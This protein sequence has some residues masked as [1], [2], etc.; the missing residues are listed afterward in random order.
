MAYLFAGILGLI[1][2]TLQPGVPPGLDTYSYWAADPDS[3]YVRAQLGSHE[4]GA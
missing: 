1:P 2:F 3:L 4:Q